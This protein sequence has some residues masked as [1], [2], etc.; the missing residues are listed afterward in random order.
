MQ[1]RATSLKCRTTT[2]LTDPNGAYGSARFTLLLAEYG[3]GSIFAANEPCCLHGVSAILNMN[4]HELIARLQSDSAKHEKVGPRL[5]PEQ[6]QE[7]EKLSGFKIPPSFAIF[8]QEF[9]DGA[10]WLYQC[11]P[12]DSTDSP[13]WFQDWH[14]NAPDMI[15]VHDSS[16]VPKSSLFCLMTEDSNGGAWCWLTSAQDLD[17]E[18]PLAYYSGEQLNFRINT[19]TDWLELL[20][21]NKIEVIRA[22]DVDNRLGLG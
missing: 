3:K 2:P 5:A 20:V 11:Q 22:L 15:P 7:F 9:G 19:F 18:F 12:L 4:I 21:E 17:G 10:H 14:E 16:T 13:S 6:V 1:K 8:L